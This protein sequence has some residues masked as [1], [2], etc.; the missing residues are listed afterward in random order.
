[1]TAAFV[2]PPDANR[3]DVETSSVGA[4]RAM[5]LEFCNV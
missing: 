1:M 4:L 2:V 3:K 5:A